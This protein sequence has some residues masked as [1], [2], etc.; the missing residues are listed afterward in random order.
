MVRKCLLDLF[1]ILDMNMLII[2]YYIVKKI[3]RFK[4][5]IFEIIGRFDGYFLII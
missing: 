2:N 4:I 3:F 5:F 1:V